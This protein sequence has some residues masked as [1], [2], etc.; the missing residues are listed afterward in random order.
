MEKERHGFVTFWI[1]IMLIINSILSYHYLRS[2]NLNLTLSTIAGLTIFI[3][4]FIAAILLLN[5]I[6]GF[7]LLLGVA[8]L[9]P[10]INHDFILIVTAVEC[11]ISFGILHIKKNGISTWDYL[12]KGIFKKC[13][14][15]AEE[16]KKEAIVCRYCGRDIPKED[17]KNVDDNVL[18]L[19]KFLTKK[20]KMKKLRE[21]FKKC[22]FCAEV[23]KKEAIVCRYCG[24]DIPK[25]DNKNIDN[26]VLTKR[27]EMKK[28]F[29]IFIVVIVA[30]IV[31]I[32]ML[33]RVSATP[34]LAPVF[35][36][37]IR[38]TDVRE[39][40]IQ[41]IN[42]EG[43]TTTV[44]SDSVVQVADQ[45]T[46]RRMRVILIMEDLVPAN[47]KPWQI[48]DMESWTITD[49]E[50]NKNFQR[51]LTNQIKENL[52]AIDGVDD[53]KVTIVF[54]KEELFSIQQNPISANVIILP[55]PGSDIT[56][57]RKKIEGIQK[58]LKTM[59]EGLRDENITITD[60]NRL[61]LNDFDG[62][63]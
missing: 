53:A 58:L 37:Q 15:C 14:F 16:I 56:Q 10:F 40:I 63:Q 27:R 9:T 28:L 44:S 31:G 48:F 6:N 11:L 23:I 60:N 36:V 57:N 62:N 26:N 38:D 8:I 2:L 52:K 33:F 7:W 29:V 12:T 4:D 55:R 34:I 42:E 5:W 3:T 49:F 13:P 59:I 61:Q 17:N 32:A 19:R 43:V 50:R 51:S 25:E 54:P 30:I 22:P 21:Y 46:A 24:R 39:R 45:A 41:R 47:A 1:W 18:T 20:C 35:N